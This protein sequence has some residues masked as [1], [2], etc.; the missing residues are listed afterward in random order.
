MLSLN[1]ANTAANTIM[2]LTKI[3]SVRF[4][5]DM[6]FFLCAEGLGLQDGSEA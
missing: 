1:D 6:S 5:S 3:N 2:A 4:Q